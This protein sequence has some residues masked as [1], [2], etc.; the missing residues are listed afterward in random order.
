MHQDEAWSEESIW[1]RKIRTDMAEDPLRYRA[2]PREAREPFSASLL[3]GPGEGRIR[4][5]QLVVW[6]PKNCGMHMMVVVLEELGKSARVLVVVLEELGK[7]AHDLVVVPEERY[8]P[9]H[10]QRSGRP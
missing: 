7:W 10:V 4:F 6:E 1:N 3:E 2:K 5:L 8:K 9:R